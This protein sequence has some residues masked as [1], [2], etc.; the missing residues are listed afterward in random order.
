MTVKRVGL[1]KRFLGCCCRPQID[2]QLFDITTS[3]DP[4]EYWNSWVVMFF[5]DVN[6]SHQFQSNQIHHS[7]ELNPL[8]FHF[9]R[10]IQLLF[11]QL[12]TQSM[13]QH[14]RTWNYRIVWLNQGMRDLFVKTI[15]WMMLSITNWFAAFQYHHISRSRVILKFL[16]SHVFQGVHHSHQFHLGQ[17]HD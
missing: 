2:S 9:H 1:W 11:H 5:Q 17:I 3:Q 6:H 12:F 4:V 16:D 7:H 8:H 14:L 13:V 15:S 10:F